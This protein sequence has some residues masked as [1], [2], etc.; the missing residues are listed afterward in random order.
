MIP[1]FVGESRASRKLGGQGSP[2]DLN[3]RMDDHPETLLTTLR[4]CVMGECR[5]CGLEPN[6]S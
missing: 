3:F 6:L 1:A 4:A 2:T 5:R